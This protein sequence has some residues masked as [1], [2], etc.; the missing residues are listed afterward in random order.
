MA[1]SLTIAIFIHTPTDSFYAILSFFYYNTTMKSLLPKPRINSAKLWLFLKT[2]L[3]LSTLLYTLFLT[4]NPSYTFSTF[5]FAFL[6]SLSTVATIYLIFAVILLPF[7]Y[8][9]K[10][11]F[12]IALT[13]VV[14]ADFL[15]LADFFI[16]RLY[17]MHINPMVLNIVFS[18]AAKESVH[19]G[20]IPQLSIIAALIGF[21]VL[22]FLLL[23]KVQKLDDT[24]AKLLNKKSRNLLV[25]PLFVIIIGEKITFGVA[26]LQNNTHLVQ[27]ARMI[28]L[29]QPLTFN[30]LAKRYFGYVPPKK[31]PSLAKNSALNYPRSPLTYTAPK[32][33]PNIFI[34]GSDATRADMIS[35][36]IMPNLFEFSKESLTFT[37]HYSGGNSTR[38]GLFSLFYGLNATYWFSFLDEQKGSLLFDALLHQGYA[39]NI[40]NS[41]DLRWPEF[42]QTAF[43]K[44]ND[45]IQDAFAGEPWQKDRAST[46][47]FKTWLS[48]QNSTAP[49]F[50]FVFLDSPHA[51]YSYPKEQAPFQPDNGGVINYMTLS[52]KDAPWLLN[53]YKNANHYVDGLFKEILESLKEKG[54]YENSII[55]ITSDHGEE[56][57]EFG[58]FGHN[59][60]FSDAQTNS[61]LLVKIP[62]MAPKIMTKLSSHIDIVPFIM[63]RIGVTNPISDYSNG[64]N[65]LEGERN[66]LSISNW[67]NYAIKTKEN[68]I[69]FSKKPS[70][71]LAPEVRRN[72]DYKID[73]SKSID[74]F[75]VMILQSLQESA[76]FFK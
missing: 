50:S 17:K 15:I 54:L 56:F 70:A 71:L 31:L 61:F 46:D 44:I 26:S 41:T 48:E 42:R 24:R 22:E 69:V 63:Q 2:N 43:V 55:I 72:S 5:S 13:L 58:N 38:F 64:V 19:I 62:N 65:L 8:L 39:I 18:P 23:K 11:S 36:E 49:L 12:Y 27:K 68:V 9:K 47:A 40:T 53:M 34:F 51:P 57:Y 33:L 7:L 16:F 59:S 3:L 75:N 1:L 73:E 21:N 29:Y 6:A 52:K 37:K 4:L 32:A 67:N 20:L 74:A 14:T 30:R 35:K 28:P 66:S 25:L 45:K 76:A 10:S 60:S